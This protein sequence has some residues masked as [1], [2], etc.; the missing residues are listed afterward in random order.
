MI[1]SD[2]VVC[3]IGFS[4]AGIGRV[5]KNL[6]LPRCAVVDLVEQSPRL[7]NA[8]PAYL[9]NSSV[10]AFVAQVSNKVLIAIIHDYFLLDLNMDPFI[11]C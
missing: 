3:V 4:L 11:L 10:T 1:E 9:S 5:A 2:C 7:L 8:A 6:L